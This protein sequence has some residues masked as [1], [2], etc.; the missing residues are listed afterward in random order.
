MTTNSAPASAPPAAQDRAFFGHPRG[1]ST[2]FFAEMWE[3]FSYYG[4]RAL[5]ILF[6]TAPIA[7]GG[8]GFETAKAGIIY[9]IYVS[10]VYL[11]ALP[12]GWI[13]D[14]FLG[15]RRSVLYGG[16]VI[17]FGHIS[18]AI[19]SLATFYLGLALVIIGTGLLKPNISTIVGE[20]YTPEDLRRDA[21]FSVYYMGIN[22][23][24]F[25][26]PLLCGWLAQSAAFRGILA[27]AGIAPELSWHFGF[28]MAAVGMFFGLIQYVLGGRF[29]GDAGMYPAPAP[30]E[31]QVRD[32]RWLIRGLV[33][34]AVLAVVG[35]AIAL[36]GSLAMT[37]AAVNR[38]YAIVL[39]VVVFGMLGWMIR[40]GTW[41][42]AE[43]GRLIAIAVLFVAAAIFWSVYEQ[44]GSTMTLFADRSTDN[45]IL[46]WEFPSSWLQSVQPGF[47]IL[48][49][50]VFG[51]IWLRLGRNDPS[52][53]AKFTIGLLLAGLS[54]I[55]MMGAASLAS[56]GSKVSPW[57]LIGAYFLQV[58]GE[59]CLSPV[60]LSAMTKLAPPRVVS[61]M[62]GF[63]FLALSLGNYLG[64]W[65]ASLYESMPLPTLFLSVGVYALVFAVIC[66]LLIAPI[67]R[68]LA[69]EG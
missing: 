14:R 11:V 58:A 55:V 19:P 24:G 16:I 64:G 42:R 34:F 17:M 37:Q 46:G 38:V 2:L 36:S 3:R 51:W 49:A 22:L 33:A 26:A 12:G 35:V 32:R 41:T 45:R 57:W 53:T 62:M 23:G 27:G 59:L 43:R 56:D 31:Q 44:A 8:L 66:G 65:V 10:L 13:A 30:P 63:W 54:F 25:F 40:G 60:G 15:M 39:G 21:G 52:S 68:M 29:L 69:R 20:L 4:M 6:M 61:L 47:I 48:F 1:L 7:V 28:A 9:G 50:P 18:L 5:L 67:R